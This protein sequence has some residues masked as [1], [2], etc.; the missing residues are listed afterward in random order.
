MVSGSFRKHQAEFNS[1]KG[2]HVFRGQKRSLSQGHL[3]ILRDMHTTQLYENDAERQAIMAG[4]QAK[5]DQLTSESQNAKNQ[6][7]V[8][9]MQYFEQFKQQY[10]GNKKLVHELRIEI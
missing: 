4:L 10:V 8:E 5:L 3:D 7:Q 6:N 9:I 1:Y 2:G